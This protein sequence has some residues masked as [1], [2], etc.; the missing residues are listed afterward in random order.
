MVARTFVAIFAILSLTSY[1]SAQDR[2]DRRDDRRE[3]R[4]DE[5]RD[6]RREQRFISGRV[7]KVVDG[8]TC[9]VE[10]RD[11]RRHNVCLYGVDAPENGQPYWK[12]APQGAFSQDSTTKKSASRRSRPIPKVAPAAT[13]MLATARSTW[14]RFAK[15][16]AGTTPS[17]SRSANS[18]KR[19]A[20]PASTTP[21]CG[22]TAARSSRGNIAMSTAR[23]AAIPNANANAKN[24]TR[25]SGCFFRM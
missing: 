11:G 18:L 5:R 4:R 22:Q 1:L 3:D 14:T 23:R 17:T 10:D 24:C 12:E 25:G 20:S 6:V 7:V 8:D 19:N 21:V 2:D 13:S 15:V 9:L 16:T